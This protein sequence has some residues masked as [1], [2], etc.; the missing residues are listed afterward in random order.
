MNRTLLWAALALSSCTAAP[1]LAQ[2]VTGCGTAAIPK[3]DATSVTKLSTQITC[4]TKAGAAASKAVAGSLPW[5][6]FVDR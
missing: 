5:R 1:A 3:A 6:R 4:F 2:T